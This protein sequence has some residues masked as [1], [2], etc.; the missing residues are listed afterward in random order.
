VF[1]MN[2]DLETVPGYIEE[3]IFYMTLNSVW[4]GG[5]IQT[6][7]QK[8]FA[9]MKEIGMSPNNYRWPSPQLVRVIEQT[10]DTYMSTVQK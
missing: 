5:W 8:T 2:R 1:V 9:I 4:L 6:D 7:K 3:D 10:R